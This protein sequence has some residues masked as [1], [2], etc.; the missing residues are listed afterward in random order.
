MIVT[1]AAEDLGHFQKVDFWISD[2]NFVLYCSVLYARSVF[3]KL[4]LKKTKSILY[5]KRFFSE[6]K[7]R[8]KHLKSE[9][10]RVENIEN[11]SEYYFL[12]SDFKEK[13]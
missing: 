1:C 2:F 13:L 7:C 6:I 5:S 4:W 10:F 9:F 8:I 11:K 3:S 12:K